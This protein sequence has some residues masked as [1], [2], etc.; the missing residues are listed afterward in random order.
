MN[1]SSDSDTGMRAWTISTLVLFALAMLMFSCKEE[2]K[3]VT[4]ENAGVGVDPTMVSHGVQTVIS[5][6]GNVRY[7]ITT[8]R[9]EMYEEAMPPHWIFPIGVTAEELDNKFKAVSTIRCDSAY[10]DERSRLWSLNGNVRITNINNETI[11]TNQMYWDQDRHK[12][13]SDSFIHV[14]RAERVIEGYGYESNENFT[15]YNLKRVQA[16][17]PIDESRFPRGEN[18]SANATPVTKPDS[19]KQNQQQ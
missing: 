15:T 16:I 17:F 8:D 12:L 18:N 9:W 1:N 3:S 6:S 14:E 5:D 7:R 10:Y 11:L 13:Y 4:K 2:L 19:T